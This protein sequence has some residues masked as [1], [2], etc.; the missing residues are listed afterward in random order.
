[1]DPRP[2][3]PYRIYGVQ[4]IQ[5]HTSASL[6]VYDDVDVDVKEVLAQ[7]IMSLCHPAKNNSTNEKHRKIIFMM[8]NCR[9][10]QMSI[11]ARRQAK[12]RVVAV[13][14]STAF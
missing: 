5:R 6:A 12:T 11:A 2:S 9:L 4:H 13:T 1:M 14:L 8:Y 10:Q 7:A 3:L